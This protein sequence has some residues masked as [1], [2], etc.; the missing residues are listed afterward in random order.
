MRSYYRL[1]L[2]IHSSFLYFTTSHNS[3]LGPRLAPMSLRNYF[4]PKPGTASDKQPVVSSLDIEHKKSISIDTT[5]VAKLSQDGDD[6][7]EP[8]SK[9]VRLDDSPEKDGSQISPTS[10]A[11]VEANKEQE[12]PKSD[13]SKTESARNEWIQLHYMEESWK[14]RL[15]GEFSKPYFQRLQAFVD[16]ERATK[17]IYPPIQNTFTAFQLCPYDNVRV[18]IIGQDP[19]HGPGQA[20]GLAF[21][22]LGG[23]LIIKHMM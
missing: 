19:Y 2:I 18:V 22:V 14:N 17:T 3:R 6:G 9:R 21:S 1:I 20:H 8:S 13:P 15:R 4:S 7:V 11:S 16:S 5:L 12:T 23:S 10:I